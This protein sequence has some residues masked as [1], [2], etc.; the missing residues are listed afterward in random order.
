M[1][2]WTRL[3]VNEA[4]AMRGSPVLLRAAGRSGKGASCSPAIIPM[5]PEGPV[6]QD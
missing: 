5:V 6:E 2:S 1:M 4:T 3:H